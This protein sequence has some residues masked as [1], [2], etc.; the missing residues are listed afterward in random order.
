M[1]TRKTDEMDSTGVEPSKAYAVPGKAGNLRVATFNCSL[2]RDREGRLTE[3]LADG[4]NSQIGNIAE[5][6]QRVNPDIVLLNEFDYVEGGRAVERFM[7]NYLEIGRNGAVPVVFDFYFVAEVN[8][9]I[10]SGV[11]LD[12]D[13]IARGPTDSFGFGMYPGQYGMALLSKFPVDSENARTFRKFLWKDMPD[14]SMPEG[15][16][17]AE[18]REIFRLSS[19]SHWDVP[20]DIDGTALHVLCSHPTPPVY[21]DGDAADGAVDWN[22]RRNHD[23]IR[24][25]ADYVTPGR[26]RYIYDDNKTAG[27]LDAGRR[28][29]ILGDQN[30]DP[31]EGDSYQHAIRQLLCNPMVNST[32]VPKS[33][34]AVDF[35]ADPDV[36]ATWGLRADYVLPS[37]FGLAAVQG[38]VFWPPR[39][40]RLHRLVENDCASSDHRLVWMDLAFA[41]SRVS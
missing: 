15:Y 14:S 17:S 41:A 22:G 12:N 27:G 6:V 19:K 37:A 40:D 18:A 21:D 11:D 32:L 33:P 25:W 8:T 30:A 9:G 3:E 36:T 24:F 2:Y 35:G 31:D 1:I 20:V 5:I 29:V 7:R 23:E 13:G 38:E 4:G 26:G 28:F 16:Y 10:P 39:S 34:G